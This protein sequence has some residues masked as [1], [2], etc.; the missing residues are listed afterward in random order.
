MIKHVSR[1]SFVALV[2]T[3][4]LFG[5][6][7]SGHSPTAPTTVSAHNLRSQ[8]V[9]AC[10]EVTYLTDLSA[11]L[12][13]WRDSIQVWLPGVTL[14]ETP[15]FAGG[16]VSTYLGALVPVLQQWQSAVNTSAGSAVLAAVPNFN[17]A[18]DTAR[19]YLPKLSAVLAGWETS[20]E[21][22]RGTN[23]LPTPPTFV[24]DTFAPTIQCL[25]DT[26]FACADTSGVVLNFAVVA[27]DDCDPAPHVVSNPPSGSTFRT[28]TTV[29]TS[30]A[31]DASGNV[32]TCTFNVTVA[33]DTSAPVLACHGDTTVTCASSDGIAVAFNVTATDACD[34]APLVTS[35][36]ASGSV[37]PVGTTAVTSTATDASGK[38]STCSFNV[39][40]EAAD[41]TIAHAAA[42]PSVL[43]PPN[44]KMV[45]IS[46]DLD[47]E[48]ACALPSTVT[49][50]DVTSNEPV[51]GTGDG[52][53]TP[54]WVIGEGG[55]LQLRAERS[56]TGHGRVYTIRL[57]AQN[58]SGAG[59]TT[60]VRVVVPHDHGN[61][62]AQR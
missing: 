24:P 46:F 56:G 34:P 29:V 11:L 37:F 59:D 32:S 25:S 6:S 61:G 16:S 22:A 3:A 38:V 19:V 13:V 26:T 21:T 1:L 35:H 36:P 20:A 2:A 17:A 5:C 9:P 31:T 47:V 33:A 8:E 10:G 14:N 4:A 45:D 39:T 51:N 27:V 50:I 12:P 40:V 60:T 7:K 28:G 55:R 44:H 41:V 57:R 62:V 48:S 49:V 52:N 42:S 43:W 54:D 58:E 23:F 53:T 30:T 15:A 18:S